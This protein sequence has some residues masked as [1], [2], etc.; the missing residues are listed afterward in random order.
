MAKVLVVAVILGAVVHGSW[1]ER[2]RLQAK[3]WQGIATKEDLEARQEAV[4][5][6]IRRDYLEMELRQTKERV[7]DLEGA[8][9]HRQCISGEKLCGF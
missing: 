5:L 2:Q 9:L 1:A 3:R 4:V 6:R 8:L 7:R